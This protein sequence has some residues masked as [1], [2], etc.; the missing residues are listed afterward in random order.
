MRW[1]LRCINQELV[2][3][4]A[5]IEYALRIANGQSVKDVEG[6]TEDG[7]YVWVPFVKVDS[8]N[9]SSYK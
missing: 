4:E 7:L 5:A 9:V 1:H 2:R 3:G 8:T 6:I